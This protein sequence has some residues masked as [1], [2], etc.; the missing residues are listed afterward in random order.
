MF[1]SYFHPEES[2]NSYRTVPYLSLDNL[3]FTLNVVQ[4]S[5]HHSFVLFH[6]SFDLVTFL[7]DFEHELFL[8]N[9]SLVGTTHWPSSFTLKHDI[10]TFTVRL[11]IHIGRPSRSFKVVTRRHFSLP[12]QFNIIRYLLMLLRCLFENIRF[13]RLRW[14]QRR[15]VQILT[16]QWRF[17][18]LLF[19][20]IF[21]I[22]RQFTLRCRSYRPR[23]SCHFLTRCHL[24]FL[25]S[26]VSLLLNTLA[27]SSLWLDWLD[28]DSSQRHVVIT[29]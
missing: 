27:A 5:L 10:F 8:R 9:G 22:W 15:F 26:K 4:A 17:A 20:N 11:Q 21:A 29:I 23:Y 25:N 24:S 18:K 19:R 3:F 12:Q 1:L 16:R 14:K 7:L 2:L 13:L 28:W 6:L